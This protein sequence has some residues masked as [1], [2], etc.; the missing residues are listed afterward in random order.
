[1]LRH[2]VLTDPTLRMIAVLTVLFGAVACTIG[3]YVS[4]LAVREF[5]LGDSG[6]AALLVVSTVISVAA[7]VYVGIRADQTADR[8][9]MALGSCVLTLAGAGMMTVSPTVWVF[10]LAHGLILPLSSTLFGQIFATARLASLAHP[11]PLRD[12]IMSTIRALFALPFVAVLPLWSLAFTAGAQLLWV[13]PACL[14]LAGGMTALTWHRWP[15]SMGRQ[16]RPSGLSFG[17]ALRE[18]AHPPLALRVLALGA[19][20][21]GATIY[22]AL[23]GL[24]LI[25]EVGRSAADVALY[26]GLV[27]G[28]EVPFM[29]AVPLIAARMRRT[30]LILTGAAIYGIHVIGLPLLAHSAWLWAMVLPA[31]MGG[32][33]IL[34]VPI[35]YLQDLLAERPG[36]GAALMALQRLSGD[37]IAAACFVIGTLLSGYGLVAVLGASVGIAAALWLHKADKP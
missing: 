15:Q 32:A 19:V 30:T 13:Y 8:R 1:M 29:L 22:M 6:Y 12:G 33:L 27:A 4:L 21:A 35:A 36:T 31:A 10:V 20:N 2:P 37:I 14:L 16:D 9:G 18:L 26:A 28:A 11:E 17:A 24:V 25:P 23:L 3:P 7:S 5:G 34:T